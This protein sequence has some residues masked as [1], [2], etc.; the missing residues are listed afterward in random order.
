MNYAHGYSIRYPGHECGCRE[1]DDPNLF[2][3]VN[4]SIAKIGVPWYNVF[5]N[6]DFNRGAT[7]DQYSDETFE[8]FYGP[9][10]YA[11][12]YGQVAFVVLKNI[13]FDASGKYKAHLADTQIAFIKN[14]LSVVP[15]EKLVVVLMHAPLI[16]CD[17]RQELFA[18][19]E[20][21]LHTF[22]V[23]A[24]THTMAHV[25]VD[26]KQGW[27]GAKPHHHFINATV[28]GGWWCGV[29][30]ESGIPH[31][32][33]NDGAPN[34]YSVITFDGNEYSIRFKAARRPPDYQMNIYVPDDIPQSSLDTL[35]VTVNVFAGSVR[36]KV[37]MQLN[38]QGDW[39][40]LE[41]K[42]MRDPGVAA[43][44]ALNPFLQSVVN[45]VELD[46]LFGWQ[47][48]PPSVSYHMWMAQLPRNLSVGTHLLKVRTTD[49]FGQTWTASR[50]FRVR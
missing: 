21:R 40:P 39:V 33:M 24:H 19:L 49:M 27:A 43:M 16:R 25:F 9:S 15:D 18:L 28:C 26:E 22:S 23:S 46:S 42:P 29:K 17:N 5:G 35:P 45:G 14:Y 41:F 1:T 31:A 7:H 37:A 6:H 47:M 10:T 38:G 2:K 3:E 20:K 36:S 13:F 30:D 32:T 8:R 44:G 12:E 11:F 4:E 34:G 48:D 50:I